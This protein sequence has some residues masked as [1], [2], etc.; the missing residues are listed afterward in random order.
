M[1]MVVRASNP[2]T[3]KAEG[4]G[5]ENEMKICHTIKCRIDMINL[6]TFKKNLP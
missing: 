6:P 3:L 2:S 5:G 1:H 4:S